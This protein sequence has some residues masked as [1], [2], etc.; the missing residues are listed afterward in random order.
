VIHEEKKS[1]GTLRRPVLE[2]ILYTTI[3]GDVIV[4][5]KLDRIARSLKDLLR[6]LDRIQESRAEFKSL[7]EIIDTQSPA[8]RMM[9]QILGAFAEFERALIQERTRVGMAAA[10]ERGAEFGRPRGVNPREENKAVEMWRSEFYS[11]TSIA[12]VYNLH[13]SSIK[14]AIWRVEERKQGKPNLDVPV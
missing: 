14:R 8:G 12:K 13:I 6:I 1:G 9:L 4:V 7:T 10:K 5:Y 2:K 11:K 3:P